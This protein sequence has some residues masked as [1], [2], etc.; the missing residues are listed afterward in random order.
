MMHFIQVHTNY[1]LN[2]V[3]LVELS[4]VSHS[5]DDNWTNSAG[6]H[7]TQSKA[8]ETDLV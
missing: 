2:Q 6:N 1:R 3:D 4:I 5:L 8:P 7:R